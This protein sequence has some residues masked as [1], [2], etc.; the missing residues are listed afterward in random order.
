MLN[1]T[2]IFGTTSMP[3]VLIVCKY[4]ISRLVVDISSASLNVFHYYFSFDNPIFPLIYYIFN[5]GHNLYHMIFIIRCEN[6]FCTSSFINHLLKILYVYY[7]KVIYWIK[8]TKF[9]NNKFYILLYFFMYRWFLRSAKVVITTNHARYHI[10]HEIG[11]CAMH[12]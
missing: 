10:Y 3:R 12:V 7:F 5:S 9:F 1:S 4:R 11:Y 6:L 2:L 8:N